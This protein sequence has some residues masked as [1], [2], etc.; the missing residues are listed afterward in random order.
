M[1][2]SANVF[3]RVEPDL[4]EQAELVL[5]Q[6]GVPMSNAITMFLKQVVLRQGIPFD[7]TIPAYKPLDL[8]TTTADELNQALEVG[9]RQA[10]NG[11]DMPVDD[12]FDEIERELGL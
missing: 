1:A 9:Y 7:V 2:K 4:K 12:A 3:A 5:D 8:S 11:Q 10:M 6:L